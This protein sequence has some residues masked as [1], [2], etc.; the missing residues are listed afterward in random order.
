MM[1]TQSKPD[2]PRVEVVEESQET[3]DVLDL[4]RLPR[5]EKL[6][7]ER[8]QLEG[9]HEVR[10][11]ERAFRPHA[12]REDMDEIRRR[13]D[14]LKI[15]RRE[16][17]DAP[18]RSPEPAAAEPEAPSEPD[19]PEVRPEH[20]AALRPLIGKASR[21]EVVHETGG[22]TVVEVTYP[23][24]DVTGKG[25]FVIEGGKAR[26][27]DEIESLIDSLPAPAVPAPAAQE[28]AP[29]AA[30]LEEDAPRKKRRFG[31]RKEADAPAA[32]AEPAEPA[33]AAPVK[34]GRLFGRKKKEDAGADGPAAAAPDEGPDEGEK[35]AK[36]R[37][38]LRRRK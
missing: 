24:E 20:E 35:P 19:V 30:E 4:D 34:K 15:E 5:E 36:K 12:S 33:E 2:K 32:P 11:S 9:A 25:L 37:F 7:R 13:V 6:K 18:P 1:P 21:V 17:P 10:Y 3:L 29:A 14:A 31:R 23:K 38:S 16:I 22:A 8:A 28:E 27:V 26:T